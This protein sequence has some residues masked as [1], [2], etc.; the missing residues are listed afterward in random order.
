MERLLAH[1]AICVHPSV[2]TPWGDINVRMQ[3][4]DGMQITLFQK[5]DK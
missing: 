5:P 3:D 2:V 4:P 1:G